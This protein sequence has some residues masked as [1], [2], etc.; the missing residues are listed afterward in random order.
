MALNP[1]SYNPGGVNTG[2]ATGAPPPT[3]S[4]TTAALLGASKDDPMGQHEGGQDKQ[5]EGALDELEKEKEK[6]KEFGGGG[7]D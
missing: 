3:S 2:P 1:A 7:K 6:E 4:E 5:G